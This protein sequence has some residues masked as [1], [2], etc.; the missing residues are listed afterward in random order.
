VCSFL[1]NIDLCGLVIQTFE[2]GTLYFMSLNDDY[3]QKGIDLFLMHKSQVFKYFIEFK[4]LTNQG[5]KSNELNNYIR[6]KESIS[7][8]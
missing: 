7:S 3:N 5:Y 1:V 4:E 6:N 8:A 2:G